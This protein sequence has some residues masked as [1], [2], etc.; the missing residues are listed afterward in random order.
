MSEPLTER[1]K[2]IMEEHKKEIE[3]IIENYEFRLKEGWKYENDLKYE[4][5]KKEDKIQWLT[6]IVTSLSAVIVI[7]FITLIFFT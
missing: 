4:I 5:E 3:N 1:E 6:S 7:Y 2:E